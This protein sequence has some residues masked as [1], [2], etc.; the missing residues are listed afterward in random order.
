MNKSVA[1]YMILNDYVQFQLAL[2]IVI[3]IRHE[4]FLR[5]CVLR[6]K[7][8]VNIKISHGCFTER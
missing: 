3:M 1:K 5:I 7:Y 4:R 6:Q 2:Q 8:F